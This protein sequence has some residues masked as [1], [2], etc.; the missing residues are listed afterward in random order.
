MSTYEYEIVIPPNATEVVVR[1][2]VSSEARAPSGLPLSVYAQVTMPDDVPD[3]WSTLL[4]GVHL[5]FHHDKVS[6]EKVRHVLDLCHA[7]GLKAGLVIGVHN[8]PGPHKGVFTRY[9][10]RLPDGEIVPDYWSDAFVSEW[11]SVRQAVA[12]AVHDHPALKWVGMDFGM[13]DEAWPT[14]PWSRVPQELQWEYVT[15]YIAAAWELAKMYTPVPVVAQVAT[16][17]RQGLEMLYWGYRSYTSPEN[18]GLKHNGF[19]PTPDEVPGLEAK[20]RPFWD[21]C[22][23]KGRVCILEPGRVPTGNVEEDR[24]VAEQLVERA[25]SWGAHALVLQPKFLDALAT[26]SG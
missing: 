15:R 25:A 19:Q 9:T 23:S 18:L 22:K 4:T 24:P 8:A 26:G 13:D 11:L 2:R 6:P 5:R 7:R 3:A 20:I 21:W 16:F 12:R 1:F 10:R 17:P 14:K